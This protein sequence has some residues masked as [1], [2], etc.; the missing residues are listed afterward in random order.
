MYFLKS[1]TFQQLRDS[2]AQETRIAPEKSAEATFEL[3][4]RCVA[5]HFGEGSDLG[6][7]HIGFLKYFRLY[8]KSS[9]DF[10]EGMCSTTWARCALSLIVYED[11]QTYYQDT[12]LIG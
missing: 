8:E 11:L 2:T 5:P 9:Y 6:R 4:G 10:R 3:P 7:T 1:L 12:T